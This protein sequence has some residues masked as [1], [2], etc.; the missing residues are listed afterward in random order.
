MSSAPGPAR[1]PKSSP[2]RTEE[3]EQARFIRWSHLAGVR[4]RMPELAWIHHSPNGGK[5]DGFT[6]AQMK[7]LG[8]RPGFPDLILP[9]NVGTHAGLAIEFKS[10]T[11]RTTPEQDGWLRHLSGQ[12]WACHVARSAEDARAIVCEYLGAD[13]GALPELP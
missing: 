5:R 7:A 13:P 10:P 1:P 12:G 11:G 2:T 3:R 6:G 9:I 4:A 8:V